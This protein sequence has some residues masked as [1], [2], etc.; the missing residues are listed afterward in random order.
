VEAGGAREVS[1]GVVGVEAVGVRAVRRRAW[2]NH[3][4]CLRAVMVG[5][6]MLVAEWAALREIVWTESLGGRSAAPRR[7]R[8]R[9]AVDGRAQLQPNSDVVGQCAKAP[10]SVLKSD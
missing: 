7:R 8:H 10:T 5:E 3:C 1:S 2:C 9:L 6:Q 4:G